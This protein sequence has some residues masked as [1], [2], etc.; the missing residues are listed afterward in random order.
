[1]PECYVCG[2][3]IMADKSTHANKILGVRH[4]KQQDCIDMLKAAN[5]VLIEGGTMLLKKNE[6]LATE[7]EKLHTRNARLRSVFGRPKTDNEDTNA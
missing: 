1:M 5:R 4:A 2:M 7:N 6:K 3:P